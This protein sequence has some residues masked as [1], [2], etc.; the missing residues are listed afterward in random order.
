MY[1][2]R[3]CSKSANL[4]QGVYT[5][6]KSDPGS[7]PDFRINPNSDPDVGQNVVDSLTCRRQAFRQVSWKSA[8]DCMRNAN[9]S[10][11]IPYSA[12]VR[13]VEQWSYVRDRITTKSY[14]VLMIGNFIYTSLF[15]ENGSNYTVTAKQ[16]A[17]LNKLNYTIIYITHEMKI[18]KH[19]ATI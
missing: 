14:T 11:K 1:T 10:L 3:L 9:K 17:G 13:E 6:T 12:V 2:T 19:F 7:N 4:R 16:T 5:A 8:G 15:T 18:S